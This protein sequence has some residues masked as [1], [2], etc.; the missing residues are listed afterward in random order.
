MKTTLEI[1]AAV[2]FVVGAVQISAEAW[3][4]LF[5]CICFGALAETLS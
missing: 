1:G 4:C 2:A 5:V 3:A